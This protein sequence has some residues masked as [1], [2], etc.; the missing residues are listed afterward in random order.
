MVAAMPRC[1]LVGEAL[2]DVALH[3]AAAQVD[4]AGQN[5]EGSP[6]DFIARP[7]GSAPSRP[8]GIRFAGML[9]PFWCSV[10][11]VARPLA[12]VSKVIWAST[13]L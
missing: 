10:R 12:S 9:A 5:R 3:D 11:L 6:P 13:T 8:H 4:G 1:V 2:L 7:S